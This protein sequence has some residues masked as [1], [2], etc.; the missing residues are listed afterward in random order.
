M[1]SLLILLII[2]AG[3]ALLGGALKPGGQVQENVSHLM[4]RWTEPKNTADSIRGEQQVDTGHAGQG[5]ALAT[6]AADVNEGRADEEPQSQV[7][8][9]NTAGKPALAQQAIARETVDGVPV[10]NVDEVLSDTAEG[11]SSTTAADSVEMVSHQ[12]VPTSEEILVLTREND[13]LLRRLLRKYAG[14]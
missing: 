8:Q 9:A 5:D 14:N 6:L 13:Q 2:A 7:A 12:P 1:R 10:P 4:Q 3:L 11:E